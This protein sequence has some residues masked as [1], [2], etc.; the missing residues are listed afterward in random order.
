MTPRAP[1]FFNE[2]FGTTTHRSKAEVYAARAVESALEAVLPDK[3]ALAVVGSFYVP[4]LA[5]AVLPF[6]AALDL[7]D[8]A[9][10]PPVAGIMAAKAAYHGA[11]SVIRRE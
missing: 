7:L 4:A 1:K 2:P 6:G 11:M 8:L 5:P 9:I 10:A 3:L